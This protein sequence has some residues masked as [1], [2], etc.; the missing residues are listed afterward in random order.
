MQSATGPRTLSVKQLL[1]L[2]V[3]CVVAMVAIGVSLLSRPPQHKSAKAVAS[4]SVDVAAPSLAVLPTRAVP[5][6][7]DP[8]ESELIERMQVALRTGDAPQAL[9]L[10]S[11]HERRFPD[12]ALGEERDSARAIAHCWL[13]QPQ[14]RAA[15]L[16]SFVQRYAGSPYGARVRAACNR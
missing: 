7:T 16:T 10:A 1:L 5:V 15:L 12:G 2:S 6:S 13:A 11:E 3:A 4:T 14:A 9:R 8:A